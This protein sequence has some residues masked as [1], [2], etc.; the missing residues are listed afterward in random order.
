MSV[1][2]IATKISILVSLII[3]LKYIDDYT[4]TTFKE[5]LG[6][7][8]IGQEKTEIKNIL[9]K[10]NVFFLKLFDQLYGNIG[11]K[12]ESLIWNILLGSVSFTLLA[13]LLL[14]IGILGDPGLPRILLIALLFNLA[15]NILPLNEK[16]EFRFNRRIKRRD[17]IRIL[18]VSLGYGILFLCFILLNPYS[19]NTNL[20]TF[21]PIAFILVAFLFF[22]AMA[23]SILPGLF[24][25][26]DR[27]RITIN[28]PVSPI[29]G[30]IASIFGI[31][32]ISIILYPISKTFLI[33]LKQEGLILFSL[34]LLN[35][36]IDTLSLLETR[37]ILSMGLR[38]TN[39]K[40][41]LLLIIDIAFSAF[42][43]LLIPIMNGQ[44]Q[45]FFASILQKGGY[46]W[47]LI[48]FISTFLTSL[49][50]YLFFI[51]SIILASFVYFMKVICKMNKFLLIKEHPIFSL[52]LIS[53]ALLAILLFSIAT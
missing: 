5:D 12:I 19:I 1:N 6:N 46:L 16:T 50:F 44:T 29:K 7:W 9:L 42:L 8:I 23:I 26:K 17:F 22:V 35:L 2:L 20:R 33:D 48:L 38:G 52:G 37:L 53:V 3:I 28:F 45:F 4:R 40:L 14:K 51:S 31:L 15:L 10:A 39:I 47:L 11:L 34:L 18:R 13:K 43:F 32:L 27:N 24:F 49:L 21:F 30:G 36:F 25:S 41:I